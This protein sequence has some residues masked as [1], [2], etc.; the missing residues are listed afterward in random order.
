MLFDLEVKTLMKQV[1]DNIGVLKNCYVIQFSDGTS[2]NP[3][4]FNKKV[5]YLNKNAHPI[6]KTQ[7]ISSHGFRQGGAIHAINSEMDWDTLMTQADW[8]SKKTALHYTRQAKQ[9]R[10]VLTLMEV[11][12]GQKGPKGQIE[13]N[14]KSEIQKGQGQSEPK[15]R[16]G[17]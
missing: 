5:K 13:H 10:Q 8:K 16:N 14:K 11:Y 17:S 6:T 12:K 4:E 15:G 7:K 2:L 3:A 9:H 1:T